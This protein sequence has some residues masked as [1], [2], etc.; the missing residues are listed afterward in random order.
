M[1]NIQVREIKAHSE[2]ITSLQ[3]IN[4]DDFK[5]LTTC[6]KD[7]QI[8]NWTLEFDLMGIINMKSERRDPQWK[9]VTKQK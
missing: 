2:V 4:L 9:F 7:Q 8:R 3:V 5:G 6:S 1:L